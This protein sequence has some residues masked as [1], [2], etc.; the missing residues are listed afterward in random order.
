MDPQEVIEFLP[1]ASVVPGEQGFHFRVPLSQMTHKPKLTVDATTFEQFAADFGMVSHLQVTLAGHAVSAF[2]FKGW[3]DGPEGYMSAQFH[4]LLT[5]AESSTIQTS[6]SGPTFS[7]ERPW[8]NVLVYLGALEDP[9]T[10]IVIRLNGEDVEVPRLFDRTYLLPEGN[11]SCPVRREVYVS[12]TGNFAAS[13]LETDVPVPGRVQW[14]HRN[15]RGG[16]RCLHGRLVF[17]E[18]QTAARKLMNWGTVHLREPAAAGR[19]LVYPPTNHVTWQEHCFDVD[20]RRSNDGQWVLTR[21]IAE[22]P[23]GYRAI[24]ELMN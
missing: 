20:V 14:A 8:P 6:L 10:T 4:R 3:Q 7:M 17:E 9:D 19:R 11:Y 18:T 21:L 1:V 12:T 5:A 23:K 2:V 22:P 16:L 13:L 15:L 24:R